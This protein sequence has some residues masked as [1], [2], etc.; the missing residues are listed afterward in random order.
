ML[1]LRH[2]TCCC[3]LTINKLRLFVI[4]KCYLLAQ[5]SLDFSYFTLPPWGGNRYQLRSTNQET[6][7]KSL[8]KKHN[9][10]I[11]QDYV[12]K[13]HYFLIVLIAYFH[14]VTPVLATH[15]RNHWSRN[16]RIMSKDDQ[17]QW[18]YWESTRNYQRI[19]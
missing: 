5:M 15:R 1:E 14:E 8:G 16:G 10:L 9:K 4:Y 2:S 6:A 13:I 18:D 11:E 19:N 7:N 3:N 12:R 17:G